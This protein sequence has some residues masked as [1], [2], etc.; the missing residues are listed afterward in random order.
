[1]TEENIAI[2]NE[3]EL[4]KCPFCGK[5]AK[6][7]TSRRWPRHLDHAIIA[8]SVVCTNIDCIIYNADNQYYETE[9]EAVAEWNTRTTLS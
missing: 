8:F 2:M 6:I 4:K 3:Y 5:E 1:M 9:L 7:T